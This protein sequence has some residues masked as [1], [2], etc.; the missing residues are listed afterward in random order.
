MLNVHVSLL[1]INIENNNIK[2]NYSSH[3]I[4]N[5]YASANNNHWDLNLFCSTHSGLKID[6]DE[7]INFLNDA[8]GIKIFKGTTRVRC[9]A[10]P[11]YK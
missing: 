2:R 1:N 10:I 3:W 4:A 6:R 5:D 8:S 11:N 7:I 9:A